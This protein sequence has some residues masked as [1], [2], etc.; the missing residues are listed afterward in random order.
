M[1]LV[2]PMAYSLSVRLEEL[3]PGRPDALGVIL[4]VGSGATLIAAPLTG[5]LSDRT[6]SRFGRRRPFTVA[7]M[8]LGLT[9]IP[10]MAAGPHIVWL[11]FGWVLC[12]VGWGTAVGSLGN[13]QADRL[14]VDQR[15]KVAGVT[16]LVMQ[17]GPVIGIILVGL[18][19]ADTFLIFAIPAA[20]GTLCVLLFVL[21]AHEVDSRSDLAQARLSVKEVVLSYGF[22]PRLVPDFAWNW[23]GRFVF[24]LG[25][26]STSSFTTFF[27]AQRLGVPVVEV[28]PVIALASAFSLLTATAGSL[29]FGWISDRLGR[30][31]PLVVV[32]VALVAAGFSVSAFADSLGPLVVG[33]LIASLGIAAFGA[34]GQAIV[35]DVLPDRA[36]QAGRYMAITAFSQKI[37][38]VI[39]PLA[40][41]LIL[42]GGGIDGANYTLLYLISAG[43]TVCG[44]CIIAIGVRSI[45]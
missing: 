41:P 29:G 44:G 35:F 26:V 27:F 3:L 13:F 7:G 16:G 6:R 39:A 42:G 8:L 9:A 11:G 30:R 15:G 33:T 12:T 21:L 31:R 14:A 20:I 19:R 10:A 24:Y 17:G 40:A 34:V 43:L 2:V 38:G 32:S 5:I 37:P 28:A 45:R 36:T 25:L 1:A 18:V 4:G 23:L 22:N